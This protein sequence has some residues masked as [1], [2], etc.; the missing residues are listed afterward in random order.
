MKA[1]LLLLVSVCLALHET[2]AIACT[3]PPPL[4]VEFERNSALLQADALSSMNPAL[5]E[6]RL[7]GPKCASFHIYAYDETETSRGLTDARA[8]EIK[9]TLINFGAKPELIKTFIERS[10]ARRQIELYNYGASGH[11]HCDPASK[12]PAYKDGADCQRPYTRCY[13]QLEDGTICNYD[14]VPDPNP[15]RYSVTP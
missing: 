6:L 12:N 7:F 1:R 2:E 15:V 4:T 11:L 9:K 3:P 8:N 5:R 13:V 14:N 10:T